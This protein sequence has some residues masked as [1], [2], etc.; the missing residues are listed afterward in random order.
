MNH[1]RKNI[2][3][4]LSIVLISII[5]TLIVIELV[6]RLILPKQDKVGGNSIVQE[7]KQINSVLVPNSELCLDGY[8]FKGYDNPLEDPNKNNP[9]IITFG[10]SHT[11]GELGCKQ[12]SWPSYFSQLAQKKVYNMGVWGYGLA[13]Y[14]YL[15]DQALSF[16]PKQIIIA[17]YLGN[18]IFNTYQT[19]HSHEG[20]E[21]FKDQNFF[22]QPVP[23]NYL[24]NQEIFLK[25]TR[26]FLR[27]KI[28]IYK[29]LGNGTR[30]L[31]ERLGLVAA[32]NVG[33]KDWQ[34]AGPDDSLVF[35]HSEIKTLFWVGQRFR[36]VNLEDQNVREGLRLA[37]LFLTEIDN[38]AKE[39]EVDL[40]VVFIPSKISAYGKEVEKQNLS[41]LL[42][43]QILKDET[44]IKEDILSFCQGQDLTC[45]DL[46][47][48]FQANLADGVK[49]YHESWDEHPS[50]EGYQEYAKII[51]KA[52][53]EE[54]D[55]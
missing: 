45:Y 49:I 39:A 40:A 28:V 31:R 43:S 53:A 38:K 22:N 30:A 25:K 13:E 3:I 47:P 4:N 16:K 7:H 12:S 52:L 33:T 26:D 8:G 29:F 42:Y 48:D 32:R 11:F 18:D 55:D 36:G 9:E 21:K 19:V 46:L 54:S 41:N 1:Q 17:V 23:K 6:F 37:K 5:M 2:L 10:D 35:N 50:S 15:M 24:K 44:E 34:S 27:E 14:Y 51:F 20:W